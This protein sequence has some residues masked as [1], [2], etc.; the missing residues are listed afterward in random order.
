MIQNEGVQ[1]DKLE[2]IAQPSYQN[3]MKFVIDYADG[4]VIEAHNPDP[5]VMEYL[6]KTGKPVL[7]YQDKSTAQYLD[8]YQKFY[9]ELF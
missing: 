5:A 1:S 8:N 3:L 2:L 6:G 4:V 9:E 7:P